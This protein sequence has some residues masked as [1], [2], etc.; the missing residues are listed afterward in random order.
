MALSWLAGTTQGVMV[1][2]YISGSFVNGKAHP[3]FAVAS[4]PT[5]TV[6]GEAMYSPSGGL[7]ADGGA[8]RAVAGPVVGMASPQP[9][10]PLT[11]R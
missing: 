9:S 4:A 10:A 3:V 11:A 8:A 2:D 1:G 5:G 7:A 6:F